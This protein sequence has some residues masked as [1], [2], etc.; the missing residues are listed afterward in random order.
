MEQLPVGACANLVNNGGLE[1]NH[2]TPWN[3]LASP[4]FREERVEGIITTTN[5]LVAWHLAI[6]LYTMF[7][8]EKFPTC[9]ANL[10]AGLPNVDAKCLAHFEDEEHLST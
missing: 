2:N 5:R 9:V 7:Q 4:C 10:Y 1:V 3:M 8:T 6:W